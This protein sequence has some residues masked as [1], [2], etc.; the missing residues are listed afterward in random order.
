MR[1]IFQKSRVIVASA[2]TLGVI[3]ASIIPAVKASAAS[4]DKVNIVYCGLNG[5]SDASYISAFK[6]IYNSN[7][8]GH[9]SSPT[10]KKDYTDI[11][12]IYKW[13]GATST[14][15]N[16]MNTTNTKVGTLYRDGRIVVDGKVVATDAWVSARFTNGSGFTKI[17]DGVYARKTTTSFAN[18]SAKVIV[19]FKDGKMVFAS[20]VECANAVKATPKETPKTPEK[21]NK[22]E[23]PTTPETPKTPET[24]VTPVTTTPTPVQPVATELPKT[25][26]ESVLGLFAGTSVAGA[27]AHH[28]ISKR[29]NRK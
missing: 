13:A 11:Q 23:T 2:L 15:V 8:S 16:G 26:P 27:A 6:N 10:V 5:S 1:N 3:A 20:M 24:P 28:L 22:P 21:P 14:M 7:K 12:A 25:G 17:A 19:Y 29:R 9:A 4:C 18:A